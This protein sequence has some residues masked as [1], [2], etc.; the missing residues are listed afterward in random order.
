MK[1]NQLY[2]HILSFLLIL[3]TLYHS[4]TIYS[5]SV[6]IPFILI[7]YTFYKRREKA[8]FPLLIIATITSSLF[9]TAESMNEIFSLLVFSVTY[10]LPLLLY[11]LLVLLGDTGVDRK[12]FGVALSYVVFTSL[13]FYLL[14]E[15]L[16]ISEFILSPENRAVQI[17]MFFGAG[18]VVAVPFHLTLRSRDGS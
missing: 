5:L 9:I 11:W 16:G 17:L 4:F 2:I 6:V 7:S 1:R 3:S 15:L 10:A 12:P 14:P 8:L 13:I 18:M